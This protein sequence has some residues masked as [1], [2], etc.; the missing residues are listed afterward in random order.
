LNHQDEYSDI[1]GH[2]TNRNCVH[3][4]SKP[5]ADVPHLTMFLH[6]QTGIS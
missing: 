3:P 5:H 4:Y 2:I 1:Y 6:R